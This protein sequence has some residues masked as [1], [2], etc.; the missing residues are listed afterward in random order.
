MHNCKLKLSGLGPQQ[1]SFHR[2]GIR[3]TLE[4]SEHMQNKQAGGFDSKVMTSS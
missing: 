4:S 1:Q 3:P 2:P